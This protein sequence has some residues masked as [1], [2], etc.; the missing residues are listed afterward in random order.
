M[1]VV[2]VPTVHPQLAFG[3]GRRFG[4]AVERNRARRRLRAAF[5][6]VVGSPGQAVPSGAYLVTADRSAI[7]APFG[8]LVQAVGRCL[9]VVDQRWAAASPA[10]STLSTP[11]STPSPTGSTG[12]P[13]GRSAGNP[14]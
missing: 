3:L 8:S 9:T 5:A 6:T 11:P 4:T 13:P 12:P 1:T 10:L 14:G 2:P 7:D